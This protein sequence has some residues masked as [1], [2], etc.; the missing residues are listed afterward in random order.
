MSEIRV[1][2]APSFSVRRPSGSSRIASFMQKAPVCGVETRHAM[3]VHVGTGQI[4][5][6]ASSLLLLSSSFPRF[7]LASIL[8]DHSYDVNVMMYLPPNAFGRE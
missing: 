6:S 4:S 7:H 2:P 3:T 8:L 5:L 1:S